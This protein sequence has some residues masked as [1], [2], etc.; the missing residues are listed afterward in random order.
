[1]RRAATS[2]LALVLALGGM[3]AAPAR[4]EPTTRYRVSFPRARHHEATVEIT[5]TDLGREPLAVR[6]SRSSP[7]R[8]RLHDFARNVYSVQAF[9]GEDRPLEVG[10]PDPWG[11]SVAGHDGTVRFSY[12]VYGD[13]MSGT[14]SAIDAT[15][16]HLN[17]PSVFA[18]ARG[19]EDRAIEIHFEPA[20]PSWRVATQ[21]EA[22][23]D[24][25]VFRAPDLQ[26]F[27]DSP[28]ELSDFVL[29]EWQQGE[30]AFRMAV[31][32]HGSDEQVE[33][34]VASTRR[35]VDEAIAV[36]GEL[37]Q[38]D[39]GTYTFIA[40][41]LPWAYGDAM[42]HRNS[43]P[44]VGRGS[45]GRDALLLLETLSHEFFHAWNV[46]RIRPASL[47][48][49]DF[50][51]ANVSE[52][53]WFA[54]GFTNYYDG[55]LLRRAGLWS[56][57]RYLRDLAATINRVALTPATGFASPVAMSRH[58][59]Y[60]DRGLWVD[61]Q[62]TTNT[63]LTYYTYGDAIGIALDLELRSRFGTSLDALM[64]AMWRSHG[65]TEKP[66]TLADVEGELAH[67]SDQTFAADFFTRY[68]HG[69]EV[70]DYRRLM[71]AAGLELR[72]ANAETAWV[73][74]GRR[75]L[76][77]DESGARISAPTRMGSPL[78]EAGIDTGDTIVA[79]DGRPVK[80][81]RAWNRAMERVRPGDR[82]ELEVQGRDGHR[83]A[84]VVVVQDP[85]LALV[86]GPSFDGAA[87]TELRR[88]W[89]TSRAQSSHE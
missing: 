57:E 55:L 88:R 42:E 77:F 82:L 56:E 68:V 79:I 49:F 30:Q 87:E 13:L 37:P 24:G 10:H 21:L 20:T 17:P 26:Y 54:E 71:A 16:A 25:L 86:R 59:I 73:G 63:Y 50:A 74:A 3:W 67:I 52:E 80:R 46:E 36:F 85:T 2:T 76:T 33:A 11:W 12:R 7:G 44:L 65:V 8:Y 81:R 5:F 75:G 35:V 78:Y 34:Y 1:M 27:L 9:D 69:S 4:A 19:L 83:T 51:E 89:Q 31:H 64:A 84:A 39:Y 40:D 23:D 45:L 53:L 29:R 66:Y 47:E 32:H 28:I 58:A 6:M 61:P 62:N 48:P 43:T 60:R 14:Y 38:F 41:Y 72:H 15:H 70:P 22:T 18:W